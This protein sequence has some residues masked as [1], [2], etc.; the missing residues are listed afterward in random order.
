M[1]HETANTFDKT[2]DLFEGQNNTNYH[3]VTHLTRIEAE[4]LFKQ[5]YINMKANF[6]DG[7]ETIRVPP[8]G[9][10]HNGLFYLGWDHAHTRFI[11]IK[12]IV[13]K[14]SGQIEYRCLQK[15]A[16]S[17]IEISKQFDKELDLQQKL[18]SIDYPHFL[19]IFDFAEIKNIQEYN[20]GKKWYQ[21]VEL[22]GLGDLERI[23][24]YLNLLDDSNI[25]NDILRYIG[26]S[27]LEAFQTLHRLNYFHGD[28]TIDNVVMTHEGGIKLI[29]F[30]F[31]TQSLTHFMAKKDFGGELSYDPPELWNEENYNTE[32]D[33]EKVEAWRIGLILLKLATGFI[34]IFSTED[35]TSKRKLLLSKCNYEVEFN[36]ENLF[37]NLN[38][39]PSNDY[40]TAIKGLLD[41]SPERRWSID[42]VLESKFFNQ[43][44]Q[45][46]QLKMALAYL[47]ELTFLYPY[48]AYLPPLFDNTIES[49][50]GFS[51]YLPA[52]CFF[53]Y[54]QRSTLQKRLLDNLTTP[55]VDAEIKI[56]NLYGV[57]G[58][59]KTQLA[60]WVVHSPEIAN[61]FDLRVWFRLDSN[62]N[63]YTQ[64]NLLGKQLNFNNPGAT[65]SF[66]NDHIEK[67]KKPWLIIFDNVAEY[68]HL[69]PYLPKQGGHILI[70]SRTKIKIP[71]TNRTPS[72]S[73]ILVEPVT[74]DE[75]MNLLYCLIPFNKDIKQLVDKTK[76]LPL[77]LVHQ[78]AY[79]LR[80]HTNFDI[81]ESKQEVSFEEPDDSNKSFSYL[82]LSE[83]F[84]SRLRACLSPVQFKDEGGRFPSSFKT[85]LHM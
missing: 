40:F 41:F 20:I 62:I 59:G 71:I 50:A 4:L 85:S 2:S 39:Y 42:K 82:Q 54:I 43:P 34:P 44:C 74:T 37:V 46:T 32:Y 64:F 51:F 12:S 19:P 68:N 15:G 33:A 47:R 77:A 35:L 23:N 73:A 28:I 52:F 30:E 11:G 22:A 9:V 78:A 26:R 69:V 56:T 84:L 25:K 80:G 53:G 81:F 45:D 16:Y 83:S 27:I 67:H 17:K 57:E 72:F 55:L 36:E 48:V 70:T 18:R 65:L 61:Y 13:E 8:L 3:V 49:T 24:S 31:T 7:I 58:V 66:L 38:K 5:T 10:G 21:M 1:K 6:I 63:L 60:V 29:D 14:V 75:A 79:I 76:C